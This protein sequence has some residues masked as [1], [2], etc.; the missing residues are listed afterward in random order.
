MPP[1]FVHVAVGTGS[2][3]SIPKRSSSYRIRASDWLKTESGS[4]PPAT[5]A[6][7]VQPPAPVDVAG[8]G[9]PAD[10]FAPWKPFG[11]P[12]TWL[13][14]LV[15]PGSQRPGVKPPGLPV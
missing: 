11:I 1:G 12:P 14:L 4:A 7:N 8:A 13:E 3:P 10:A 2:Q 5:A 15:Q 9:Q 6:F